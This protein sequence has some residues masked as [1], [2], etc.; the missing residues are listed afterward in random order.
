MTGPLRFARGVTLIGGGE[1]APAD[2]AEALTLAPHLV[3]A[4]S[5]A[6]AALRL[7]GMPEAV[8]GDMDSISPAARAAIPP[9][10]LHP[11][12]EQ[13]STDF[14]KA[15]RG[16]DAPFVLALGFTGSRIDHGLAAMNCLARRGDKRVLLIGGEDVIFLAPPHLS[17]SLPLA[18]RLSLFP[19]GPARGR[20][21]GLRWPIEG[22]AFAPNDRIGTSNEVTGPV[23]LEL[24]GQMLVILP[25]DRLCGLIAQMFST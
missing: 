13:D 11:V 20:S 4:D 1:I 15:L 8:F 22:I 9:E 18:T 19:M 12:I 23:T 14:D 16:I 6:D 25:R 24:S 21:S 17:L 10:R 3:A 5:G 2:L 7:G